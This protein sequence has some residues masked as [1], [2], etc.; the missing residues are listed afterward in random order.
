MIRDLIAFV[1]SRSFL[2][3]LG[4]YALIIGLILVFTFIWLRFYTNHGETI[5]VP[6]LIE[7][8]IMEAHSI[9]DKN[10]L[11]IVVQDSVYLPHHMPGRV[12]SQNPPAY[13][14]NSKGDSVRRSVKEGRK[15][16]V[17]ITRITPPN[18]VMP[19]L[20]DISE[21]V[22]LIKLEAAG[23]VLGDVSYEPNQIGD[24]LILKQRYKGK[25]IAPGTK[26]KMGE[27]IDLVVSKRSLDK[28]Q[29]PD[30]YG[31]TMR[32]ARSFLNDRS[33]NLG[34]VI[35]CVNCNDKT[36]SLKARIYD[37]KPRSTGQYVGIGGNVDIYM[38]MDNEGFRSEKRGK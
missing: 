27:K 22:A 30:L 34:I 21:R 35:K 14:L 33:L 15:I 20:V 13:A 32:E 6:D 9:V 7:H 11:K 3:N 26:L 4:I 16:Y 17:T 8:S 5:E 29:V 24:N 31:M 37:Q 19:D 23:L 28:K 18:K 12:I 2:K 1:F 25:D 38:T 36:D 10:D